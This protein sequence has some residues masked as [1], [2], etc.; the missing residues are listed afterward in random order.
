MKNKI[1]AVTTAVIL[2]LTACPNLA[3]AETPPN[4]V[5][6]QLKAYQTAEAN[7]AVHI[8]TFDT[9]DFGVYSNQKWDRLKESHAADILVHYPDGSTTKGLDAHIAAL[10]PMFI[11]APDTKITTHPVKFGQGDWTGV[12]GVMTGTFTKPMPTG[13][14]KTIALTG[15]HFEFQM[16]TIGHWTS[17]GVMDEEYLFWDNAAFMKQI[18]L[19]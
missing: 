16:S 3:L 15:K 19:S 5:M 6:E 4:S 9:L 17:A 14:G 12:I 7:T 1:R 11:F 2:S 18:G 13:D 10:K 8:K